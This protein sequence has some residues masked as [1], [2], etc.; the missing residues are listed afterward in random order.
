WLW[1][2]GAEAILGIRRRGGSLEVD[3]CIPA[4]W[5]GFEAVY[6]HGAA[7]YRVSVANPDGVSRGVAGLELDGRAVGS[8][9]VPLED[10]GREHAVVVR[11]GS[12]GSGQSQGYGVA[13]PTAAVQPKTR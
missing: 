9:L 12:R 8:N 3:P 11:L 13:A 2:L 5:E 7:T 10:D 6:R 1:R 4:A